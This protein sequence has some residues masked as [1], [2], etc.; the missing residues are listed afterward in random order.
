MGTIESFA[1]VCRYPGNVDSRCSAA[2]AL[3]EPAKKFLEAAKSVGSQS[4]ED[5]LARACPE[6]DQL[7]L[8]TGDG[9]GMSSLVGQELVAQY[10][11]SREKRLS[12]AAYDE[13]ERDAV[14]FEKFA[15]SRI[16]TVQTILKNDPQASKYVEGIYLHEIEFGKLLLF[17]LMP[18][19]VSDR[20]EI[21]TLTN[22]KRTRQTEEE[23]LATLDADRKKISTTDALFPW[24]A[25][26]QYF[27]WPYLIG[28]ALSLK[29]GKGVATWKK[30]RSSARPMMMPNLPNPGAHDSRSEKEQEQVAM[31]TPNTSED[32][33]IPEDRV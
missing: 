33:V 4:V 28:I 11:K 20:K 16:V 25:Q 10:K 17:G 1:K 15:Q 21:E 30:H 24:L 3:Y 14:S 5:R 8:G 23:L 22:W 32:V 19:I 26:I 2:E 27:V 7:I 13:L 29:F 6:A 18:C 31:P 9:K 12:F